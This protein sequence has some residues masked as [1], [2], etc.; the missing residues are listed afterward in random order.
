ML[1]DPCLDYYSASV[2]KPSALPADEREICTCDVMDG[3]RDGCILRA[4]YTECNKKTCPCGDKCQNQRIG[5][6]QYVK[7]KVMEVSQDDG[8]MEHV[9]GRDGMGW[10]GM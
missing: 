4:C 5:R 6:H 1:S 7:S 2:R 8:I 3:C 10:D 9:M